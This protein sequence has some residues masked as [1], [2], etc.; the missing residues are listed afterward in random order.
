MKKMLLII[1]AIIATGY[2]SV[3]ALTAPNL[4]FALLM[5]VSLFGWVLWVNH[6]RWNKHIDVKKAVTS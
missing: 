3:Q 4:F 5:L 6:N 2:I 1:V